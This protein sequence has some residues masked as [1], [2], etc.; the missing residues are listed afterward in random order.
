MLIQY[1]R[2]YFPY[3]RPFLHS[4]PAEAPCH[5]DRDPLITGNYHILEKKWEYS[6]SVDRLFV[7]LRR[8]YDLSRREVLY[9]EFFDNK[10]LRRIFGPKSYELKGE[11]R[12]LHSEEF[13]DLSCSPNIVRVIILL[14]RMRW[15]GH[16]AR[17][18]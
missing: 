18:W 5:A 6:E 13:N 17:V 8:A 10:V 15:V 3:W 14:R 12:K 11:W 7:N 9:N 4:Q 16:V 1:I 2:S